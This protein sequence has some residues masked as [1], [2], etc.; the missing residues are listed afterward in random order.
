MVQYVGT[1]DQPH[2]LI[3]VH[4]RGVGLYVQHRHQVIYTRILVEFDERGLHRRLNRGLQQF[5]LAEDEADDVVLRE[6]ADQPAFV[7]DR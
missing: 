7:H 2:E 1:R 3:T 5:R 6:D 4:D